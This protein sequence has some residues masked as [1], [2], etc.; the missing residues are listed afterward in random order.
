MDHLLVSL[1]KTYF[2]VSLLVLFDALKYN[3]KLRSFRFR[4]D[5]RQSPAD[6]Y[7]DRQWHTVF[8]F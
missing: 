4:L 2:L 8:S 5:L 6:V 3:V 7:L 1:V